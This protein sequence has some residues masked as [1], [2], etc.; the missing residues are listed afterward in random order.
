MPHWLE[1]AR[2]PCLATRIPPAAATSAAVVEMLK[3]WALSPPVPTISKRSSPASTGMAFSR[4]AVA[5]PVISSAVSARALL[6]DR[7]ARN[8]AFWVA[9]VSPLMISFMTV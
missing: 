5:Q 9:V 4:M 7:A 3:E 2:L 6:V 1:A 8:A